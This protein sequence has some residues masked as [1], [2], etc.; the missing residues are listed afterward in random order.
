MTTKEQN[1]HDATYFGVCTFETAKE[2]DWHKETL[3]CYVKIRECDV[4]MFTHDAQ[5]GGYDYINAPQMHEIAK[6]LPVRLEEDFKW[7]VRKSDLFS[8]ATQI[9]FS[10]MYIA[11]NGLDSKKTMK[12]LIVNENHHYAEAYA[13][14]YIKLREAGLLEKEVDNA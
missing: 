11:Q 8:N 13:L 3:F 14:L 10:L 5:T 9:A 7:G 6:E 4:V 2:L 1:L 12:F